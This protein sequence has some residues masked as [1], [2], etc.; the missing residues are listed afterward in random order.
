MARDPVTDYLQVFPFW[1]LDI[2]PIEG[3]AAP[4]FNPLSGFSSISAPGYTAETFDVPEGNWYTRRKVIRKYDVDPIT[5]TRGVTFH[6]SDFYRWNL[7]TMTGDP[8]GLQVPLSPVTIGGPTPRRNLL[9]IQFFAHSVGA[10]TAATISV[11]LFATGI[12][13]TAAAASAQGAIAGSAALAAGA[14]A[15]ANNQSIGPFEINP[16]IPAKAWILYDC[17]PTRFKVGSDF[18][19]R[20][21]DISIAEIEIHPELIEEISLS[22]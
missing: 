1:L 3:I 6:D 5:L 21:S 13:A 22:S 16:R 12:A 17:I 18:D 8:S 9:L 14:I 2:A 10:V 4:I 11:G 20:S 19:A 15:S 7:A